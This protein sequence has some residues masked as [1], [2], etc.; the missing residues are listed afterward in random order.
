MN[1]KKPRNILLNS[2]WQTVTMHSFTQWALP[3]ML[4]ILDPDDYRLSF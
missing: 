2:G 4:G 1:T 3:K